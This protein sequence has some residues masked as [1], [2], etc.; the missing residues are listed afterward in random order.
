MG[1]ISDKE[2]R[3][4]LLAFNT[5]VPPVTG[6]T[7]N[8]LLKKLADL[9]KGQTKKNDA[10]KIMPPP[11]VKSP[12][13]ESVMISSSNNGKQSQH[14]I[15]DNTDSPRKSARRRRQY[16]APDPFDT[17]D[18]EVDN[19]TLGHTIQPANPKIASSSPKSNETSLMN[20]SNWKN[21]AD[22]DVHQSYLSPGIY[23][24]DC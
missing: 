11:N 18:S 22:L 16:R 21:T 10:S 20:V 6:S 9:E 17:S 13:N 19:G 14:I 1:D 3:A 5:V 4:R 23:F 24:K 2:L 8:L 7:R 15:F 12:I